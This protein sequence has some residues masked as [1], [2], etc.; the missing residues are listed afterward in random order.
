[1]NSRVCDNRIGPEVCWCTLMWSVLLI[2]SVHCR[3][4]F[5]RTF[6]CTSYNVELKSTCCF[7]LSCWFFI[8]FFLSSTCFWTLKIRGFPK[9]NLDW[10]VGIRKDNLDLKVLKHTMLYIIITSTEVSSML[11]MKSKYPFIP[12]CGSKLRRMA[13]VS[14]LTRNGGLWTFSSP[15]VRVSWILPIW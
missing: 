6:H 2:I 4:K 7:S 5:D 10:T 12:F 14:L 8:H 13:P 15:S 9:I 11:T 1:M 3:I